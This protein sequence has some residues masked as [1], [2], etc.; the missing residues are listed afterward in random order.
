MAKHFADQ[1]IG[2]QR[3]AVLRLSAVKPGSAA[4]VGFRRRRLIYI[5]EML[6]GVMHGSR[7]TG[8]IHGRLF[9]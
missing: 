7:C 8:R 2:Q 4:G 9:H 3:Y 6:H 5:E 1:L